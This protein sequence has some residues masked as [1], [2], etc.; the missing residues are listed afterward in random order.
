MAEIGAKQSSP[1]ERQILRGKTVDVIDQ[2]PDRTRD[3]ASIDGDRTLRGITI[4]LIWD[5]P[6]QG[7]GASSAET[8]SPDAREPTPGRREHFRGIA[9]FCV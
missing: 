9:V 3:F 8:T 1:G 7:R 2:V 5:Y 6:R 4:D